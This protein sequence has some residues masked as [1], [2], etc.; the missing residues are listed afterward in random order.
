MHSEGKRREK[1]GRVERESSERRVEREILKKCNTKLHRE[2]SEIRCKEK[3][4][5]KSG[6]RK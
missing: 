2:S 5:R 3:V 6:E 1:V 4:V